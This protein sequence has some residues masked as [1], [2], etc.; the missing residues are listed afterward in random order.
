V[1]GAVLVSL[2]FAFQTPF[3]L[4]MKSGLVIVLGVLVSV[5]GQIGD[6]AESMLKRG[7][8]VKDSGNL[9]PGHGGMLD[10]LDSIL[11]AGVTVYLFYALTSL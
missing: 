11:F 4:P 5:F 3:Q 7:T 8:G 1:V 9:M 6:L 10:R 2:L